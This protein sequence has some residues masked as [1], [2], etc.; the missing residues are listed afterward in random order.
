MT[1]YAPVADI[2]FPLDDASI[3]EGGRRRICGVE[4]SSHFSTA[5]TLGWDPADASRQGSAL[6][7]SLPREH[8]GGDLIHFII[9]PDSP[10]KVASGQ[11]AIVLRV[12]NSPYVVKLV[13]I[14]EEPDGT[15]FAKG[16]SPSNLIDIPLSLMIT[17]LREFFKESKLDIPV[18]DHHDEAFYQNPEERSPYFSTTFFCVCPDLTRSGMCKVEEAHDFDFSKDPDL[19][20]LY[21]SAINKLLKLSNKDY[22]ISYMSHRFESKSGQSTAEAAFEFK[23]ALKRMFFVVTDE[24]NKRT[25]VVGDLDHASIISNQV[26]LKYLNR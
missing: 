7:R 18:I 17:T 22:Q 20:I 14:K 5:E 11:H 4:Q 6:L 15:F 21:E 12:P 9:R 26:Y 23:D 3:E 13:G 19:K 1:A 10:I 24:D 8:E 25:L 16:K 2:A